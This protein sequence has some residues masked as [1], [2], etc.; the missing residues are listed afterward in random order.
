MT[1]TI[2]PVPFIWARGTHKSIVTS[3]PIG[4]LVAAEAWRAS[5][6]AF[7]ATLLSAA[8]TPLDAQVLP[9]GGSVVSGK[10]SV[11]PSADGLV[12]R[13]TSPRMVADW[14]SFSIGRG[15]TVRF[16]QP[17]ADAVALNRVTGGSPSEIF[18]S[19]L[20]NGHVYLQN[21]NGVL[22]GAGAQVSVGSL[23]ATTLNADPTQFMAGRLR[24][25]GGAGAGA[26]VRNEGRIE[27]AAGGYAVLA[28]PLT[29][30]AGSIT[31][32]RGTTALVAA[33]AV[34]VDPTGSGLMNISVSAAAVNARLDNTG[35]LKADGGVVELRAAATNAA[36]RTVMQVDGLVRA[37]SIEQRGGRIVLN[38]GTS[39]SVRVAATLDASG[40]ATGTRG[41]AIEVLGDKV[42]LVGM[43][44]LDVSGAAGG[45]S[46][47]V[48]GAY[49]GHGPQPNAT[50]TLVESKVR[51]DAGAVEQGDG[52]SIVIW[53]DRATTYAGQAAAPGG[54]R[55]GD[56]GRIEISGKQLL[57]F[58]G[59]VDLRAPHGKAGTLL[60]DPFSLVIGD[61]ADANGDGRIG[62]DVTKAGINEST[63]S[64][65]PDISKITASQVATL[66]ASG[67]LTLEARTDISVTSPVKVASDGG[68]TT[69]SL[70][71]AHVINVNAAL[72]LNNS[73]LLASTTTDGAKLEGVAFNAPVQSL[74]SVAVSSPSITLSAPITAKS[75]D[76]DARHVT[77]IE[78][79][80]GSIA[81]AALTLTNRRTGEPGP[82]VAMNNSNNISLLD[83][84]VGGA[85]IRVDNPTG[86]FLDIRGR[87]NSLR[88]GTGS[89]IAQSADPAGK[90]TVSDVLT[91]QPFDTESSADGVSLVN[92]ANSFGAVS[93][94]GVGNI[95]L[96]ALNLRATGTTAGSVDL[97]STNG[98]FVMT[99]DITSTTSTIDITGNGFV[100]GFVNDG[101][102]I[103]SHILSVPAG[104]RFLV[105]SNDY[106][107]DVLGLAFS[108]SGSTDF[109]FKVFAGNTAALPATGNGFFTNQRA[110]LVA[111]SGDSP[112]ISK[113]YDASPAFSFS[114][115]GASTSAQILPDGHSETLGPYTVRGSGVFE[116]RNVGTGKGYTTEP[117]NDVVA[118]SASGATY[119]GLNFPS[120]SRPSGASSGG[121]AANAVSEITPAPLVVAGV[122]ALDR[123]YD[124]TTAVALTGTPVVAPL[125]QDEVVVIGTG[126]GRVTDK[127]AAAGK[128]VTVEGFA[129]S[130]SDAGNYSVIQPSG[131]AITIAPLTVAPVGIT[132]VPRVEDGTTAVALDS[133]LARLSGVL[134]GDSVGLITTRA[135][136]LV[137]TPDPGVGKPVLVNGLALAGTD[138]VNYALA[139]G[140][141]LGG[142]TVT[143]VSSEAYLFSRLRNQEYLQAVSQAQQPLGRGM[144]EALI[145][146]FGKESIREPLQLGL[147][148]TGSAPSAADTI[149]QSWRPVTC[150]ASMA[151]DVYRVTCK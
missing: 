56:G 106:S 92:V 46:M 114:Q 64:P 3:A 9:T 76:F 32:P 101:S 123:T 34:S 17:T 140:F 33:G 80:G 30:N 109:N 8:A 124:A 141:G 85:S 93:F 78:M 29:S 50:E 18:G 20:S 115:T 127:N 99:G 62:D 54:A 37:Q 132:A 22:F 65:S 100:N 90:L 36:Q 145:A 60:L 118:V 137:E 143:I 38:G 89:G 120:F 111:P 72:T 4:H 128:P 112:P 79:S 63:P 45:G 102:T 57:Q 73:S 119:F 58:D 21:P 116:N 70:Q 13:Q 26:E 55:G 97:V 122:R 136:G 2:H 113:I 86:T 41:G 75:V 151:G 134:P 66:L 71:G 95:S 135:T 126:S 108:A 68:N 59:G 67:N 6:P 150:A 42:A 144:N 121:S 146:G 15:A 147:V 110:Q 83:L 107:A 35:G 31:T 14:Q 88:L 19:L 12:I 27:T 11:A 23:V 96:R 53:S 139:S 94:A 40:A 5:L 25:S 149:Y 43:A 117:S 129:L 1:S 138:A 130:G 148:Q 39:G 44:H 52:G 103:G 10:G 81:A 142:L 74:K 49:R 47:L 87:A 61:I 28:G 82:S 98:P 131:L 51:L 48:G 104:S 24:L 16:E 7:L 84:N 125:A 69:L 105:R 77:E 133:T 91:L